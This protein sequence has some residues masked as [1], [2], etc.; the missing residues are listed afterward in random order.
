MG[1]GISINF[2]N[3][4]ILVILV[5]MKQE[6]LD[7]GVVVIQK[8]YEGWVKKGCM[9]EDDVKVKMVLLILFLF[10]D[11]LGDVDLVIEVVF[12]EMGVK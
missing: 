5:E 1:I 12:E 7:W 3:V 8:V 10:Y 4:G 2:L 11:D 6:G 9:S